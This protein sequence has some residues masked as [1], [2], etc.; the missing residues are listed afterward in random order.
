MQ[1]IYRQI[2]IERYIYTKKNDC[3]HYAF[4]STK[5]DIMLTSI[6][7][8]NIK[9]QVLT[10]LRAY[11]AKQNKTEKK[12]K[13]SKKSVKVTKSDFL[14]SKK[15]TNRENFARH[16]HAVQSVTC[17]IWVVRHDFLLASYNNNNRLIITKSYF[18]QK[19]DHGSCCWA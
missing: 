19:M 18:V 11:S 8:Q 6:G 17:N 12:G 1:C 10:I 15:W 16:I 13:K 14:N 7:N 4:K 9:V 2:R 5:H 3:N